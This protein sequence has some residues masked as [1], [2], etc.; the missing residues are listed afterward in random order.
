MSLIKLHLPFY[1]KNIL[2]KIINIMKTS[3]DLVICDIDDLEGSK[4]KD[5]E[6]LYK[7]IGEL[8]FKPKNKK[9]IFLLGDTGNLILPIPRFTKLLLDSDDLKK[10]SK[11]KYLSLGYD[12]MNEKTIISELTHLLNSTSSHTAGFKR[13][14]GSMAKY[15]VYR[16]WYETH[17]DKPIIF[18]VNNVLE[19]IY[20]FTEWEKLKK[21]KLWGNATLDKITNYPDHVERI[22]NAN[23]E[24]PIIITIYN[25][26]P[27]LLDGTHR[28]MK[29]YMTNKK[30]IKVIIID[31][32][33]LKRAQIS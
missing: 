30:T 26:K 14:D 17:N 25:A 15:N 24:Y 22:N 2:L 29:A 21:E 27:I 16:L 1:T 13:K 8:I 4:K 23:L 10:K 33:K 5:P 18:E 28:L 7:E 3:N 11:N 31:K 32:K 20:G 12:L 9:K 19:Y 6:K